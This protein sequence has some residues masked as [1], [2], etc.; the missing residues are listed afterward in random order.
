MYYIDL[1]PNYTPQIYTELLLY[2]EL[3][4]HRVTAKRVVEMSTLQ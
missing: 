4:A 2:L 3:S 1:V